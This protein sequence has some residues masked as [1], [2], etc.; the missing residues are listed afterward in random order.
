MA[1]GESARLCSR[2]GCHPEDGSGCIDGIDESECPH[3][4]AFTVPVDIEDSTHGLKQVEP[5]SLGTVR[6]HN[7]EALNTVEADAF[8][9]K[10]KSTVV[11]F[12]GCP[13]AGKTTAAVML[14]E[15]L[16]RK[17]L[18]GLGFV[19]CNTI[20]G[21]QARSFKSLLASGL[22]EPDTERTRRSAPVAFL[23]LRVCR[24]PVKRIFSHVLLS[25]R[26]GED[27]EACIG[28]P[29]ICD[30]Y[31]EISRADC[32]VLLVNG[33]KLISPDLAAS[34]VGEVRRIFLALQRSPLKKMQ[35]VLTKFDKVEKSENKEF[36]VDH[37]NAIFQEFQ[38]RAQFPIVSHMLAARPNKGEE[39]LGH[40]LRDIVLEWFPSDMP[41]VPFRKIL[42][43]LSEGN[44]YDLLVNTLGGEL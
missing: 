23:H 33:E 19:G 13:D 29:A 12:V 22:S 5:V 2:E 39:L 41:T 32:H 34:H 9:R 42:P 44:A 14:Y 28:K 15:L 11:A 8:L 25:D 17:R 27:F 16:K 31:P 4:H 3:R 43:K 35:L 7:G 36:A 21:F 37:F 1:E 24:D 10:H 30:T 40:G 6:I 26:T 20:R 38:Q 18:D